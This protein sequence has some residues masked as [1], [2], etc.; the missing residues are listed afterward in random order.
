VDDLTVKWL[1][2]HSTKADIT[3]HYTHE[4]IAVLAA[5]LQKIA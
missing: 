4:T 3:S 5:A 2:G 1:M